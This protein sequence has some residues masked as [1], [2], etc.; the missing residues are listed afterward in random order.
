MTIDRTDPYGVLGLSANATQR[1]VRRA[2]RALMRQYHPDTRPVRGPTHSAAADEALQ[3]VITAYAM[4]H[5]PAPQG[6]S[7]Q[8]PD[9]RLPT[10]RP[11]RTPPVP[12]SFARTGADQAPIRVGPVRWHGSPG[13]RA[14]P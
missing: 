10:S 13:P 14:A 3:Q 8:H 9:V 4:L 6:G 12:T 11:I 2:Y 5:D 7:A 1:Q